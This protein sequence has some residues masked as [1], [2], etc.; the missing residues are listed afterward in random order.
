MRRK[1]AAQVKKKYLLHFNC[2]NYKRF[3][4]VETEGTAKGIFVIVDRKTGV[5][6][7][8]TKFGAAGGVC[9]LIDKDGKPIIT[10][11]RNAARDVQA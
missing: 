1:F 5:N 4:I 8:A 3:E 6:Y 2:V 7:L 10:K 9:P 11:D